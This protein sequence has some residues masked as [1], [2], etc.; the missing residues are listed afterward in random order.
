MINK[1]LFVESGRD[2]RFVDLFGAVKI[3]D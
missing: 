2:L 1:E 3:I